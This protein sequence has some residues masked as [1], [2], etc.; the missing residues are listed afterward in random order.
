[1]LTNERHAIIL[2]TLKEKQTITIQE[3]I[4]ATSVSESTIR[5]PSM[6]PL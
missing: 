1:M 3:L 5:R 4:E 6:D 2:K